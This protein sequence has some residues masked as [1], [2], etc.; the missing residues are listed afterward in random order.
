VQKHLSMLY[1]GWM[2]CIATGV[3]L[4]CQD[5]GIGTKTRLSNSAYQSLVALGLCAVLPT[6][7]KHAED[8]FVFTDSMHVD[9]RFSST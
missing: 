6:R 8:A 7:C 4:C 5:A 2:R 3:K 1:R 9:I